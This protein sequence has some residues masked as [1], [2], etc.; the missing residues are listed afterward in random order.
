MILAADLIIH[1]LFFFFNNAG[2]TRLYEGFFFLNITNSSELTDAPKNANEE[3]S[4]KDQV[5]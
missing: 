3:S 5:A 4:C 2:V 1:F